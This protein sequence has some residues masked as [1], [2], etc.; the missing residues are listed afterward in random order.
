MRVLLLFP[1]LHLATIMPGTRCGRILEIQSKT[2]ADHNAGM[3]GGLAVEICGSN[4][5]CCNA[6]AL[7]S[8]RDDFNKGHVDVFFGDR[9]RECN[10][11]ELIDGSAIMVVSHAGSD[12]WLGERIRPTTIRNPHCHHQ[13]HS[14]NP[15]T[16]PEQVSNACMG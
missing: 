2:S 4:F 5:Y 8:D 12:A 15:A 6:G 16:P 10:G 9:I 7:D 13:G 11:A 3:N 14:L 1:L